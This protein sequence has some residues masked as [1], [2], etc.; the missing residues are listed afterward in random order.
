[1]EAW[2]VFNL[3]TKRRLFDATMRKRIYTML[4]DLHVVNT[5]RNLPL[6]GI[7]GV[8]P[9]AESLN[10]SMAGIQGRK[11]IASNPIDMTLN[12]NQRLV[13]MHAPDHIQKP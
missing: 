8:F 10:K 6:S 12:R 3:T 2:R 9:N 5:R 4:V 11:S 7:I 1:M 13:W